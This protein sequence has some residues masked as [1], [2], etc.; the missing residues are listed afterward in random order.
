MS[1]DTI[2]LS[3]VDLKALEAEVARRNHKPQQINTPQDLH[4]FAR[5]H[6]L[7]PD[8]HEPDESDIDARI[9]GTHL[10]NATGPTMRN[11]GSE[12]GEFNVVLV[13]RGWGDDGER[14]PD[15]DLAVINLATLL[16]WAAESGRQQIIAQRAEA[17]GE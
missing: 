16:S 12:Y 14:L 10:D 11:E 15:R 17:D 9:I 5:Q 4:L 8:W 7:R 6:A 13:Q 2:D 1:N 3:D